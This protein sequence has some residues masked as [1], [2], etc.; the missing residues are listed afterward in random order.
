MPSS[1]HLQDAPPLLS[2]TLTQDE[3]QTSLRQS[4]SCGLS[5]ASA[6]ES[7]SGSTKSRI[8]HSKMLQGNLPRIISP[9]S[10][11]KL[12]CCYGVIMVLS[13]A[14]VALS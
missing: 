1:A 4:S 10:P 6:S 9:E 2:R 3:E 13:V 5:A 11:A 12:P 14:V 8:P 7:L